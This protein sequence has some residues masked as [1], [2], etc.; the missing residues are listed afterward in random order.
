MALYKFDYYLF[1]VQGISDTEGEEKIFYYKK[2]II[3]ISISD[4]S[5]CPITKAI[6]A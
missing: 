5:N 3:I 6:D 1:Y 4:V 2:I